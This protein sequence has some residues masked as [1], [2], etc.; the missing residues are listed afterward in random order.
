MR[1]FTL[2]SALVFHFQLMKIF[3]VNCISDKQ[4]EAQKDCMTYLRKH[5]EVMAWML[6]SST[7]VS[8]SLY[9]T[10]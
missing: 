4:I 10:M 1:Y 8:V 9:Q 7:T 3:R 6:F 5:T 2:F